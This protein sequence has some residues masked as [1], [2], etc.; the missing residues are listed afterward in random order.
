MALQVQ[1]VTAIDRP[2]FRLF[3]GIEAAMPSS[4]SRKIVAAW[5][6]SADG[7][8]PPGLPRRSWQTGS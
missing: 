4:Q 7:M 3:N 2:E 1:D 5:T 6:D 8:A